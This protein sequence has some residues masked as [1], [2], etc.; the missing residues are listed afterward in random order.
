MT[1]IRR[2]GLIM[3]LGVTILVAGCED[4]T[5]KP[6]VEFVGGGFI[7]NYRTAN[8]YYGFVVRQKKPLPEGSKLEARFEVPWGPEQVVERP[9]RSGQ[10]QYVFQT[11]DLQGI[12]KGHPYKASLRILDGTSGVE[13]AKYETSFKTDVDQSALP[14]GPLVV[15]PGYE[16]APQ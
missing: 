8:H 6:Y 5:A 4:D 12:V 9:S 11:G 15:G 16:P 13:I 3:A 1:I 7:F 2:L 10:L 14:K